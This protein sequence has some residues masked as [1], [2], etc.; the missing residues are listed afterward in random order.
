[1]KYILLS[2]AFLL[3]LSSAC[4]AGPP[5]FTDDP[6]PVEFKHWEIYL[7]SQYF[8]TSDGSSGTAPHIELNYGAYPNL[9]LHIIAPQNFN[10]PNGSGYTYG[11]GDTEIG[12][13]YRFI[14]ETGSRPQIGTFIQAELPTGDENKNLGNGKTQIFLPL[15]AQKSFGPWTTYGGGGY[16]INPGTN[17]KNWVFLGWL[18]QRDISKY[19]TLGLET[20]YRTPDTTSGEY[21]TGFT[22]GGQINL[23]EH[24]HF[25]FSFGNNLSGPKQSTRYF[26]FQ[27][28][29]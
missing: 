9:Q 6:E 10:D 1:M 26:A 14:Q 5:F 4:F 22:S 16:W 11:Y 3:I 28:T 29:I 21:S 19:L 27:L 15:W 7:A 24:L 2:V 18:L 20:F 25:L 23:S 17:N 13:K 12:A 8:G